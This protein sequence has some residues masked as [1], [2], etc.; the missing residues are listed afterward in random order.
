MSYLPI[1]IISYALNGFSLIVD[2]TLLN[3][4]LPSP[5]VYTFYIGLLSALVVFLIP[6]GA[7]M[8]N[9]QGAIFAILSGIFF[10]LSLVTFFTSMRHTVVTVVGPIVGTVNPVFALIVGSLILNQELV[11]HQWVSFLLLITGG[12]I[13]T[14]NLWWG[15]HS[16][17]KNFLIMI[18]SGCFFG[19]SYVMLRQAFLYDSF[20]NVLIV[21]RLALTAI[22]LIFLFFPQTRHDIFGS[23]ITHNHFANKT[24]ALVL[25]SQ[26]AGGVSG[27]MLAWAVSMASPAIVNSIYGVQYIVLL[28]GAIILAKS[29]PHFLEERFTPLV[30]VQKILAVIIISLGL[31]YLAI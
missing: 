3:E 22:V 24:S 15:K 23:Q 11:A 26:L 19:L 18:L 12:I 10:A 2:K 13:L 7:T 28:G 25:S 8:P 6:L 4:S 14:F 5:Y 30:L 27:L 16:L 9:L 29:H 1:S 31:V 20:L 17:D 21:S